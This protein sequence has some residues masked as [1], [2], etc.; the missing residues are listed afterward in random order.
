M[1]A[2]HVAARE[3]IIVTHYNARL[4]HKYVFAPY[5]IHNLRMRQNI[6]VIQICLRM[7]T[8]ELDL[9]LCM[10]LQLLQF[11]SLLNSSMII[12]IDEEIK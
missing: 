6:E 7:C 11:E 10:A 5:K 9:S 3:N 1:Q 8:P 12:H 4:Y 2:A